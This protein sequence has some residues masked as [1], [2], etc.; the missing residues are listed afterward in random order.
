M[1]YRGKKNLKRLPPF[2]PLLWQMLN[3]KAYID[4][5]PSASKALPYFLGK[6]KGNY[7]DPERYTQEFI[8]P[9]SEAKRYGFAYATH[10]KNIREL[11][12]NGFI[13]PVDKGGLRG[14]CRS[15]SKFKLSQRWKTYGTEEFK[16]ILWE[17]CFPK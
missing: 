13:D 12:K 6:Y 16:S 10:S 8:F 1:S 17:R 2:V 14:E 9:Y 11:M 15:C 3:N 4:L 7:Y 5:P